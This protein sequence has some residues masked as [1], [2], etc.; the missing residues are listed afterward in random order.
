MHMNNQNAF[1]V[2]DNAYAEADPELCATV[3][4]TRDMHEDDIVYVCGALHRRNNGQPY[5]RLMRAVRILD[6]IWYD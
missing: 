5:W 6:A 4:D 3:L 1:H 2:L